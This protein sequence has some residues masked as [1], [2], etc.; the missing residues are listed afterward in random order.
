MRRQYLSIILSVSLSVVV[1][2]H[3]EYVFN[4]VGVYYHWKSQASFGIAFEHVANARI[5]FSRAIRA[6]SSFAPAYANLAILTFYD[7][8]EQ[9]FL[10]GQAYFKEA[11][12]RSPNTMEL[13]LLAV[14]HMLFFY[15]M[16]G[17]AD[18][19]PG[20]EFL[21]H[22]IALAPTD[23]EVYVH[24]AA[25]LVTYDQKY[26]EA[27]VCL[28]KAA[29]LKG[30]RHWQ[31]LIDLRQWLFIMYNLNLTSQLSDIAG[32]IYF[33]RL[34]DGGCAV[35]TESDSL[36]WIPRIDNFYNRIAVEFIKEGDYG[37]ALAYLQRGLEAN[38]RNPALLENF[39][40]AYYFSGHPKRA[41]QY[42][43][44][45]LKFGPEDQAQVYSQLA[46]AYRA[47]KEFIKSIELFLRAIK[48]GFPESAGYYN[49]AVNYALLQDKHS[50]LMYLQK[51]ISLDAD[52]KTYAKNDSNFASLSTNRQFLNLTQD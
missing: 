43:S 16:G 33:K 23:P 27:I 18:L 34:R 8:N 9:A 39:G 45:A 26:S 49:I 7:A 30:Q 29:Q 37:K 47:N 35:P 4:L 52:L 21:Q 14:Q 5:W 15:R 48:Y 1:V 40:R 41:I 13:Y 22:A 32:L 10:R 20:K 17:M 24:K 51:A 44:Q 38:P 6:D 50:T 42:L 12:A 25:F 11:I 2:S 28:R 46:F 31:F 36:K 19:E 3:R